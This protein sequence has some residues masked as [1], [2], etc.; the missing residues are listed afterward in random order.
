VQAAVGHYVYELW[1]GCGGIGFARSANGGRSFGSPLTM[2]ESAGQ[3]YY[4]NTSVSGLPKFGWDPAIAVGP[5]GTVYAS[6]MVYRDDYD[7]PNVH[8]PV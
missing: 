5:N 6:Y 8:S 4:Q 2:P 1:I 3:G 7:H